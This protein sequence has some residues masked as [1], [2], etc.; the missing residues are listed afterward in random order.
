MEVQIIVSQMSK[1]CEQKFA[2]NHVSIY[3]AS[4]DGCSH[5]VPWCVCTFPPSE[6]EVTCELHLLKR[7]KFP[8]TDELSPAHFKDWGSPHLSELTTILQ[9][10]YAT[11]IISSD[12]VLVDIVPI[13]NRVS[14]T[15]CAN[16]RGIR[17]LCMASKML[18]SLL[19]RRLSWV[20]ELYIWEE[21]AEFRQNWCYGDHLLW[22]VRC[23]STV[24]IPIRLP[25]FV[26]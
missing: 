11:E 25:L 13:L 5:S 7:H 6:A 16:Y 4:C 23:S 19:L 14:R 2:W 10:I 3:P 17:L 15:D 22:I 26:S 1:L 9:E 21:Q 12:S 18:A 24:K 20:Q 8:G